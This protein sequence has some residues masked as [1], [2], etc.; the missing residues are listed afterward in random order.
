V[1]RAG[2]FCGLCFFSFLSAT[3]IRYSPV[4]RRI[5]DQRLESFGTTNAARHDTISK[6]FETAGCGG[7]IAD[8][9]VKHAKTPNVICSFVGSSDSEI[10]VGA[11]YDFVDIGSGVIDNWSGASMLPSLFEGLKTQPRKHTF[12]FIAFTNEEEGL[13]GSAFYLRHLPRS[14]IKKIAAMVNLDSLGAGPTK[15]EKDRGD[16]RLA[17]A[18]VDVATSFKLPLSIVDVHRV[19][20]SDSDSFQDSGVPTINLHSLTQ[21]T[22]PL[23]HSRRDQIGAVQHDDYYDSYRLI[24]AYLAYLDESLAAP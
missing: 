10:V 21:Q 19:G 18:L 5:V 13:V 8:Q 24:Q 17:K 4:E 15:F 6:L 2:A 14:E 23:L 12:V 7:Q 9:P 3:E 11:H 20:R 22:Y 16:K 1:A